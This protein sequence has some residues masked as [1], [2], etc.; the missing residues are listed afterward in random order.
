M[1]HWIELG[2]A[3]LVYIVVLIV[4]GPNMVIVYNYS[5][6]KNSSAS[7]LS[8][9]GYGAAATVLAVLSYLGVSALKDRFVYFEEVMF[10]IS[11][12]LLVWFGFQIKIIKELSDN[13]HKSKEASSVSYIFSA[14]MLN[15]SNP[16]A[17]ALLTSI[18]GGVLSNINPYEAIVF[19][20]FCFLLEIVW[21]YMLSHIFSSNLVIDVS[22]KYIA[23]IT[24]VS[25]MLLIMMGGYFLI[26]SITTVLNL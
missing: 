4:P 9:F 6:Q 7:I 26:Y 2:T 11:G 19:I 3:L 18:Y 15:V 8:G 24:Y 22:S 12:S 10:V 5:V 23:K 14:F 17:I 16:K 13:F 21:Y 25:K 1:T 20:L